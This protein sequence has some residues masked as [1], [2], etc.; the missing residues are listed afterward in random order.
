[1]EGKGV[2]CI[3]KDGK[4][5]DVAVAG[6]CMLQ[7]HLGSTETTLRPGIRSANGLQMPTCFNGCMSLLSMKDDCT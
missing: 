5:S 6:L 2:R 7:I 1:M 3:A 4:T